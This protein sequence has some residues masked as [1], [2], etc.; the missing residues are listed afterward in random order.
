MEQHDFTA[1][2][3]RRLAIRI[4]RGEGCSL[5]VSLSLGVFAASVEQFFEQLLD[6]IRNMSREEQRATREGLDMP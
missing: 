4:G 6:F 3:M 1:A 5:Q 2:E